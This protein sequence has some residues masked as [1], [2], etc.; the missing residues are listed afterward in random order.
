MPKSKKPSKAGA[1]AGTGKTSSPGKRRQA[2]VPERQRP[3]WSAVE[4][5]SVPFGYGVDRIRAMPVDPECLFVYWEV[6]DKAIDRSREELGAGGPSASLVVRVYDTTGRIFDGTNAH[7]WFD[8]EV[9]RE[10]R[11]WFFRIDR[12]GSVAIVELGLRSEDG[13]F[14]PL[15]RSGRVE[16]PRRGPMTQASPRWLTVRVHEG[17]PQ[18][19]AESSPPPGSPGP[20][21]IA[22]GAGHAEVG[23]GAEPWRDDWYA[24]HIP[25]GFE[26]GEWSEQWT[27]EIP[28]VEETRVFHW[29]GTGTS[30]SWEAGPFTYEVDA[31]QP[32]SERFVGQRRVFRSGPRTHIV[33]GPWELLIRGVGAFRKRVVLSRWAVHRSWITEQGHEVRRTVSTNGDLLPGSSASLQYGASERRWLAGSEARLMGAS[34]LVWLGASE[35][36]LGGASERMYQAASEWLAR[37]ASE[38]RFWGASERRLGGASER[39]LAGAS[40]GRLGGAS[41]QALRGGSEGRPRGAT[42][43]SVPP[44]TDPES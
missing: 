31:P 11:Q 25:E 42:Y 39:S 41:E 1:R 32:V 3:E 5:A 44:E 40:E 21:R 2:A 4:A 36:R 15:A 22:G 14:A 43:P 9:A 18:A 8:Q 6:T 38:R 34:E 16:F 30:T 26:A 13:S 17:R 23:A 10:N 35:R 19:P 37:G 12:P 20:D 27:A 24:G 33:E 29:E 28:T 7:G